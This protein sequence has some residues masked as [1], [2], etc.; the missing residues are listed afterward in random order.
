MAD[1]A[2]PLLRRELNQFRS[3]EENT[4]RRRLSA[5]REAA[6]FNRRC[7]LDDDD[8]RCWGCC[9]NEKSTSELETNRHRIVFVFRDT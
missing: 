9:S 6:Q 3:V 7:G 2:I 5:K 1:A 8:S 4:V